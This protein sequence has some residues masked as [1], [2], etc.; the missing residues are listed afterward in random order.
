MCRSAFSIQFKAIA[1]SDKNAI[2]TG[3]SSATSLPL[4]PPAMPLKLSQTPPKLPT[5]IEL[6]VTKEICSNGYIVARLDVPAEDSAGQT[7]KTV[8]ASSP[9]FTTEASSALLGTSSD[10]KSPMFLRFQPST[11]ISGLSGTSDTTLTLSVFVENCYGARSNIIQKQVCILSILKFGECLLFQDPN[12]S[13]FSS[14]TN[15]SIQK[16]DRNG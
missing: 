8:W 6:E 1:D 11:Q 16:F 10:P 12:Q 2:R 7:L 3:T 4:Q 14:A 5:G 13:K 15:H 9:P